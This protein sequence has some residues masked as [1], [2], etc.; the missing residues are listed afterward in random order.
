MKPYVSIFPYNSN[1]YLHDRAF[2]R[3]KNRGIESTIFLHLQE[4]LNRRGIDIHTYDMP[5]AKMASLFVCFDVPYPWDV[6]AWGAILRH[7]GPRVLI[8]N[9]SALIIPFNYW[10]TIHRLFSKVFTW[11]EPLVDGR[12][13]IR[14]RLP[15]SSDGIKTKARP[16]SQKKF[17]VLIN[18]N[19]KPFSLFRLF[20][21]FGEELYTWRLAAIGFFERVIPGQF[22]LYGRGWNKPKK[23]S[24]SERILGFKKYAS[25]KGAVED[26][27]T[28]LSGY[29]FSIC[30]ENLTGVDGYVTEKIFDC[31]K[32]R[33]VPVYWGAR[34]I[35]QYIPK[36]CFIDFRDF[37][38][39][40]KLL[41]FITSVDEAAYNTYIANIETLLAD[42][43]FRGRWFEEWFSEFFFAEI[44]EKNK[45]TG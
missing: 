21:T 10:K 28:V 45:H 35:T 1:Q 20:G 42:K 22:D 41:E 34:D 39:F 7:T 2:D 44:W 18:K 8:A 31:L 27:F 17:L 11:H 37:G 9:E 30:F 15:K 5:Q 12:K 29:K 43:A 25:Y 19:T 6:R 16:F 4:F 14:I 36:N 23:Y 38:N 33:C 24:L 13:Y 32:A 26:K 40:E 3:G